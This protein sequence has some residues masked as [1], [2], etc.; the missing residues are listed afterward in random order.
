MRLV[1]SPPNICWGNVLLH[2]WHNEHCL[3]KP[4]LCRSGCKHEWVSTCYVFCIALVLGLIHPPT[5]PLIPTPT[6]THPCYMTGLL[7]VPP[8]SSSVIKAFDLLR[9]THFCSGAPPVSL[10]SMTERS[11]RQTDSIQ[12][13]QGEE[14]KRELDRKTEN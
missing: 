6:S 5:P 7:L 2:V 13:E 9:D 8:T 4:G 12:I 14:K 3:R 10:G 1:N 11:E